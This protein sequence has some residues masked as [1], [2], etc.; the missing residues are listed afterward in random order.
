MNYLDAVM[1]TRFME[2]VPC[3]C[4]GYSCEYPCDDVSVLCSRCIFLIFS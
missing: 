2:D 1:T 4:L 3:G